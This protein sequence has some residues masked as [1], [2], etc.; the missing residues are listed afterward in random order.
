MTRGQRIA[1]AIREALE[2]RAGEKLTPELILDRANNASMYVLEALEEPTPAGYQPTTPADTVSGEIQAPAGIHG[3][4]LDEY[5]A[6]LI[7]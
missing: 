1:R 7:K 5:T 6:R 2:V 4:T 3:E